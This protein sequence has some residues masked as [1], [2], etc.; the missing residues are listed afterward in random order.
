M[1]NR[2][3]KFWLQDGSSLWAQENGLNLFE[4]D[5]D[6]TPAELQLDRRDKKC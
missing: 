3:K 2:E 4:A 1:A 5:L 6:V